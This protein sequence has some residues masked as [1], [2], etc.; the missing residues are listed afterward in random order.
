MV[1]RSPVFR[2]QSLYRINKR[3]LDAIENDHANEHHDQHEACAV[4]QPSPRG[5]ARTQETSAEG[6]NDGGDGVDVSYPAPPLRY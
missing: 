1:D 3:L 2:R 5:V 6:L 4:S